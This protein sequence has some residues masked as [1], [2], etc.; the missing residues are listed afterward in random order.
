MLRFSLKVVSQQARLLFDRRQFSAAAKVSL[1]VLHNLALVVTF[2][3]CC[4]LQ[5]F[6]RCKSASFED[7]CLRFLFEKKEVALIEYLK[8]RL[9]QFGPLLPPQGCFGEVHVTP[10]QVM[11]FVWI[12][13]LYLNLLNRLEGAVQGFVSKAQSPS[14]EQRQRD[15]KNKVSEPP[16]GSDY[17]M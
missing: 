7:V 12:V 10:Q 6:A 2:D 9:R 16:V 15:I 8:E 17:L 1:F 4:C 14:N 13:Q 11:L 5:V 3:Q